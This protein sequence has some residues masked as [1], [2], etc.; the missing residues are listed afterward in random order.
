MCLVL[1]TLIACRIRVRLADCQTMLDWGVEIG[2]A[3]HLSSGCALV[4]ENQVTNVSGNVTSPRN[5]NKNR[6]TA[7]TTSIPKLL[8]QSYKSLLVPNSVV[9]FVNSW[10]A[11]LKDDD[12]TFVW[13]TDD[14]LEWLLRT[15]YPQYAASYARMPHT[16]MKVD[17]A[18]YF[19]LHFHGG[20]YADVDIEYTPHIKNASL[21]N[22]LTRVAPTSMTNLAIIFHEC[23]DN[24]LMASTRNSTFWLHVFEKW[25]KAATSSSLPHHKRTVHSVSGVSMLGK[26]CHEQGNASHLRIVPFESSSKFEVHHGTNSWRWKTKRNDLVLV[27]DVVIFVYI[28]V[29]VL[30]IVVQSRE[31]TS[32]IRED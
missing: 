1:V 7:T 20:V 22:V 15:H 24:S 26:V 31:E 21:N 19:I 29:M 4:N 25:N 14:D 17:T 18:R 8:H 11:F 32:R 30:V 9:P 27:L 10:H 23:T 5:L 6:I 2:H 16:I 13:W 28:V 12:W 3:G